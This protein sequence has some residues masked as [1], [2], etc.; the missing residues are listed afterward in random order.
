MVLSISVVYKGNLL[1]TVG[2]KGPASCGCMTC[3]DK[4]TSSG[5]RYMGS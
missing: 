1:E 2:E 5:E 3:W 4:S